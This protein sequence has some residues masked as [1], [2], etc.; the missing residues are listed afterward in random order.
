[1]LKDELYSMWLRFNSLILKITKPEKDVV[2]DHPAL[3]LF[4][5][6]RILHNSFDSH[7]PFDFSL[8]DY[9]VEQERKRV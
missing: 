5:F 3:L 2:L 6:L 4:T 1:M 9:Y 8:D 7:K